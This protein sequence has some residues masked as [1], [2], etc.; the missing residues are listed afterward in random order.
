MD[1]HKKKTTQTMAT[2]L[3]TE[4]VREPLL[5]VVLKRFIY[6]L[7]IIGQVGKYHGLKYR[8]IQCQAKQCEAHQFQ[9]D[10]NHGQSGLCKIPVFA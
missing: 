4:P 7:V 9:L 10:R 1:T 3:N 6:S 8:F 2:I 5:Q